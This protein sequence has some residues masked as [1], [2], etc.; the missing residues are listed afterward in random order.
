MNNFQGNKKLKIALILSISLNIITVFFATRHF[1]LKY[2]KVP[3]HQT[4]VD[5]NDIK[6]IILGDSRASGADWSD[7]LK[8]NDVANCGISGLTTAVLLQKMDSILNEYNP[9]LCFIQ[10]GVN[11]IRLKVNTETVEERYR[12]ILQ[13]LVSNKISPVVTSTIPLR[14]D[15]WSDEVS[16][17]VVNDRVDSLNNK[18][19]HFCTDNKIDYL[20]INKNIIK[21]KRLI[22]EYTYDG[23][24][25]N[26]N[27]YL[28][29]FKKITEYL[30]LKKVL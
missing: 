11:D 8:R 19:F 21:D 4:S 10:I 6:I 22:R 14:K 23:I 2:R 30:E 24:H 1:Y 9:T 16:E 7:G 27:G 26:K 28:E 17:I 12:S 3:K 20:D 29:V 5:K 18:L 25:L 15:Y 13:K